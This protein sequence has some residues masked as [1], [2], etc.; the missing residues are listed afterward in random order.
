[1]KGQH[2]L[3]K[4][5]IRIPLIQLEFPFNIQQYMLTVYLQ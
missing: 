3:T 2:I 1:M 5:E 4:Y